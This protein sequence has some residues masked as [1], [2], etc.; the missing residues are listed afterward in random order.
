MFRV[1][2]NRQTAVLFLIGIFVVLYL[3]TIG[4]RPLF[5]PDE[6]RYAEIPR[7][8]L[9]DHDWVVPHFGGL[10]YFEKP[11]MGYW[12]NAVSLWLFGLNEFAVR[13]AS[14]LA[15]GL[16]ALL[17]FVAV[18][19][20]RDFEAAF[21]T[22][23]IFLSCGLVFGIGTFAV[24]DGPFSLFV[25]ASLL[26]F[27]QATRTRSGLGR[28]GWLALFGAC[29]GAAFMTKGFLAFV[30]PLIVL[31]P[32]MF[33]EKRWKE[34][35]AMAP[36]PLVTAVLVVLPWSLAIARREPDF[37]H[38]FVVVEHWERMVANKS[39][40]HPQP[41]WFYIPIIIG[42]T[43][44]WTL[45]VPGIFSRFRWALPQEGL[46]RYCLCWLVFPFIFFSI[47]SGKLG[48][49]ILPCYPALAYLLYVGGKNYF[50]AGSTRIFSVTCKVMEYILMVGGVGFA[51]MQ[52]LSD[53]GLTRKMFAAISGRLATVPTAPYGP[54]ETWKWL[55]ILAVVA[56]WTAALHYAAKT[57]DCERRILVFAVGAMLPLLVF[58]FVIPQLVIYSKAPGPFLARIADKIAPE[59]TIVAY[60]NMFPA[61]SWY[62]RRNDVY[63]LHKGGEMSYGLEYPDAAHRLVSRERF[64]AMT[65]APRRG[66]LIFLMKTRKFRDMVL[67]A[68]FELF[69]PDRDRIMFSIYDGSTPSAP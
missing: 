59:D 51:L 46:T 10:C 47:A 21:Y 69:E 3:G 29:C 44:P 18:R 33:W 35:F 42:G 5:T 63:M 58:H 64:A 37:W 67:P 26:L 43:M 9:Q 30:L 40:Q 31:V 41:F 15:A 16:T 34:L 12:L 57:P 32:F 45:L 1:K 2:E 61:V 27:F 49:Y 25:T 39:S 54:G 19:R 8:I 22:T 68:P 6:V 52:L 65:T 28:Q 23:L 48:T 66:K 60:N 53:T 24:L 13:F 62:F 17:L 56:G 4:T 50:S 7:E 55:V 11:I 38:Y 14:A 36:V 20:Y